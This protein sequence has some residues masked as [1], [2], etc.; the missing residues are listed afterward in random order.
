MHELIHGGGPRG[1]D[2]INAWDA[3][4]ANNPSATP[5][6]VFKQIGVFIYDFGLDGIIKLIE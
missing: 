1:G 4:L 5:Q 2:W 6:D 3:W